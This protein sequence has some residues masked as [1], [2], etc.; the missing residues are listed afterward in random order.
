MASPHAPFVHIYGYKCFNPNKDGHQ[1]CLYIMRYA[2]PHVPKHFIWTAPGSQRDLR[3][4]IHALHARNE[5]IKMKYEDAGLAI[6]H[7]YRPIPPECEQVPMI[8]LS[9]RTLFD[10]IRGEYPLEVPMNGQIV[11]HTGNGRLVVTKFLAELAN[12][13]LEEELGIAEQM[14]VA[15]GRPIR[16]TESN[17]EIQPTPKPKRSTPLNTSSHYNSPN[18]NLIVA[19]EMGQVTIPQSCEE[20]VAVGAE[21]PVSSRYEGRYTEF[22]SECL[23]PQPYFIRRLLGSGGVVAYLGV[24]VSEDGPWETQYVNAEYC[25]SLGIDYEQ[26]AGS[27][28]A[29]DA[30]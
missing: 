25:R 29:G 27:T 22:I 11:V 2:N 10:L 9:G 20:S 3:A 23:G 8:R 12:E 14:R 28:V 7:E 16:L 30:G 17:P 15:E 1:K 6:D 5:L 19:E 4:Y 24:S 26:D 21:R 13:D 18:A